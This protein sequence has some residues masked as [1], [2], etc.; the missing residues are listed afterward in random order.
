MHWLTLA[1]AI[2]CEVF[3]TTMLKLS[4]GFTRPLPLLGMTLG[5]A[6]SFYALALTL[7]TLPLGAAYAI[8]GGVGLVLTAAVGVAVFG[9]KTDTAPNG[10]GCAERQG[11]QGQREGIEGQGVAEGH[12]QER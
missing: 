8:W 3:A 5:Y 10:V 9:E 2:L 7:K 6:L 11:F 1:F 12:A 4:D